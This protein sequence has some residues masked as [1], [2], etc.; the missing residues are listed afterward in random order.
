MILVAKFNE[1][2]LQGILISGVSD[3]EQDKKGSGKENLHR[4]E[5]E[6]KE[7]VGK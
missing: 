7:K 2:I 5:T 1:M 6:K 4:S 3:R